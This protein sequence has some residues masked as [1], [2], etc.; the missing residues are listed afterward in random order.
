MHIGE[1][2]RSARKAAKLSQENLARQAGVTMNLVSRLERGEIRD[3]HYST[4]SG[5]A[6]ALGVSVTELL[7]EE[8]GPKVQAPPSPE[9][10]DEER[11]AR[12]FDMVHDAAVEQA[13]ARQ[14]VLAR[15][16]EAAPVPQVENLQHD[17]QVF[18]HL[19][20]L[21]VDEIADLAWE[22]M[23]YVVQLEQQLENIQAAP[24]AGAAGDPRVRG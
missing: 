6:D 1:H 9:D 4:L 10:T 24:P 16:R 7:E 2:I 14:Q 22:A 20:G 8:P 23:Q 5:I 19:V 3:P 15:A 21:R 13:K 17:N 12:L 18:K 11:R